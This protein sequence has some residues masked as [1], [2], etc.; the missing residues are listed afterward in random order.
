MDIEV[1]TVLE[2]IQEL[3]Y[4]E[5][6]D[7][8]VTCEVPPKDNLCY[9]RWDRWTP[10][11]KYLKDYAAHHEDFGGNFFLCLYDG[12]RE[13]TEPAIGEE[14]HYVSWN[15]VQK[16]KYLGKGNA[17]EPRFRHL[18]D[19]F[20][21][22]PELPCKVLTY[23]RHVDDRNALLIPDSEFIHRNCFSSFTDQVKAHDIPWHQKKNNIIWRGSP[24]VNEGYLWNNHGQGKMHP[25]HV[26]VQLSRSPVLSPYLDASFDHAPISWQLQN[27]YILDIDGMVN[28][29]SALYWKLSSNS[30][31]LKTKSHWEQWYYPNLQPYKSYIPV[32]SLYDLPRI[33]KWCQYN[34][35]KCMQIAKN[36][37]EFVATLTYEYA[38]KEYKIH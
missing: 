32:D 18:E 9:S 31:V 37:S 33:F 14:R 30:V 12:W 19:N 7:G 34:D 2:E 21:V 24:N 27:K 36:A 28:A 3:G 8:L 15:D 10:T 38:V 11:L 1:T 25:R 29:W 16:Y 20:A 17:G 6:R 26:A 22:Y 5:I 23:N 35:D 4:V 13:Y